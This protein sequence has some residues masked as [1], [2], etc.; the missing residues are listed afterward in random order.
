MPTWVWVLI[1]AVAV[2]VAAGVIVAAT[3]ASGRKRTERLKQHFG[4]EYER[5]VSEAGDQR[6]SGEGT[7]HS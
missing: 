2:L 4:T 7:H 3:R 5:T 6:R 1:A